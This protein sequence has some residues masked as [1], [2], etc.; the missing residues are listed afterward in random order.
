MVAV[1]VPEENRLQEDSPM[2]R[3]AVTGRARKV[4]R[5]RMYR[6]VTF[7]LARLCR[8]SAGF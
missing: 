7:A 6:T 2:T 3:V 8:F 1:E 4:V 5:L